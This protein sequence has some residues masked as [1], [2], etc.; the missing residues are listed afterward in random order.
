MVCA[1]ILVVGHSDS[2]RRLSSNTRSA[3]SSA[4]ICCSTCPIPCRAATTSISVGVCLGGMAIAVLRFDG[5]PAHFREFR[6]GAP[7]RLSMVSS[8]ICQAL[9]PAGGLGGGDA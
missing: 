8:Q 4:A 5:A 1:V 7:A 9:D 3:A 6:H 2:G